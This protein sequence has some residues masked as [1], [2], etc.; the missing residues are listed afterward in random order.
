M[1][2]HEL[3]RMFLERPDM[4]VEVGSPDQIAPVR[5]AETDC[6]DEETGFVWVLEGDWDV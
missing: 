4:Q 6:F 5:E 2:S 1:R 3:A